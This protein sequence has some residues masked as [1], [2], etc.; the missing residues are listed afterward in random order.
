MKRSTL[1]TWMVREMDKGIPG[2][3]DSE[4]KCME[5]LNYKLLYIIKTKSVKLGDDRED[6]RGN[7]QA[8][9]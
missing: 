7:V 2:W 6:W 1:P 9:D 8:P 4:S 5:A 3:E